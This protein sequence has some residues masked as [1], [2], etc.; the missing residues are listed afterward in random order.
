M[1]TWSITQARAQIAAV[2][3]AA[4]TEG[5]QRIERRDK[6]SVVILSEADWRKLV[7]AYESFSDF[8]LKAPL[9]SEDLPSR[10]PARVIAQEP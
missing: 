7:S 9:E 2:A 4:L 10:R 6:D 1:K 8:I 3:D 5:P